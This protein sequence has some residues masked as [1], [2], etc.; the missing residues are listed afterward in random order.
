MSIDWN[1]L[2]FLLNLSRT[3]SLTRSA[4]A[5]QVSVST[6]SRRLETLETSLGSTLFTRHSTGVLLTDQGRDLVVHAERV[7]A[8]IV[9]L[10]RSAAGRD[11]QLT[12]TVRLATAD[13]LASHILIPALGAFRDRYPEIDLEIV[14]GIGAVGLSRREADLALRLVEPKG[15]DLIC[16]KLVKQ[17]NGLYASDSYLVRHPWRAEEG[18]VGHQLVGW[19]ESLSHLPLAQWLRE[20]SGNARVALRLTNLASQIAA[21]RAGVGVAALPCFLGDQAPDLR[22]LLGPEQ[23][24]VEDLWLILHPDLAN[25]ARVRAVADFVSDT[26]AASR[27]RFEGRGRA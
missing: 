4:A 13:T 15:R 8:D 6:M 27:E 9:A 23:V 25:S 10:E 12:G 18:L 14:T 11:A 17:A 26:V 21:V 7:E 19:D 5:M 20:A 2:R 16:R 24:F 1:D 22:R 3:G